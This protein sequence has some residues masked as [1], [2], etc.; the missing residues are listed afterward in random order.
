[1]PI[2]ICSG[3]MKF[4][5]DSFHNWSMEEICSCRTKQEWIDYYKKMKWM[6]RID[7]EKYDFCEK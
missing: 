4:V 7:G 5:P 3:C 1:M 2:G 6:L